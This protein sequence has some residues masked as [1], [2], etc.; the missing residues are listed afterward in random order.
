MPEYVGHLVDTICS[1]TAHLGSDWKNHKQSCKRFSASN[2]VTVK[3]DY[4]DGL[5]VCLIPT[6]SIA[7]AVS[8]F[9]PSTISK[10]VQPRPSQEP[11]TEYPKKKIIKVQL[12][13]MPPQTP[14]MVYDAKCELLCHILRDDAPA[15]FDRLSEFIRSKGTFGL[16]AYL[17]AELR[18]K[19]ELVIK[20]DEALAEQP[21]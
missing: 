9:P 20:I 15:A 1:L 12:P 5:M 16:K 14:I 13:T 7:R 18:S 2:T 8:G 4:G 17:A 10:M 11:T 21:F 3:P 6:Q 19:D